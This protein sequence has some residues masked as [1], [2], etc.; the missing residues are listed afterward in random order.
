MLYCKADLNSGQLIHT[1]SLEDG[2]VLYD[3]LQ[4]VDVYSDLKGSYAW[5]KSEFT[6]LDMNVY[7]EVLSSHMSNIYS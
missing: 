7:I 1:E 3:T 4:G 5:S 2:Y 6:P